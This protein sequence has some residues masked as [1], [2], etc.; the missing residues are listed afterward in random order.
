MIL[1]TS[2][3]GL[4]T[5]FKPYEVAL[6]LHIW[7]SNIEERTS[8]SS[9]QAYRFLQQTGESDLMMSRASVIVFLNKMVEEG[10]LE[11][12]EKTGKGG[13]H[14]VYYPKMDRKQFARHVVETITNKLDE[15]FPEAQPR[16]RV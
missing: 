10:V 6:L 16:R 4:Q 2:K 7:E 8:I 3:E 5:L 12:E 9:G 13:R 14:R 11:Y 1:D 15:V